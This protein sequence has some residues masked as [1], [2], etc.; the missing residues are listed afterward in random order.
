MK[1]SFALVIVVIASLLSG[2][3]P[4]SAQVKVSFA[5]QKNSSITI[6]GSSNIT[7]FK[8]I[9]KGEKLPLETFMITATPVQNK[10]LISENRLT[11]EVK[12]FT[13]GNKMALRDFFKLVKS[14]IYP[15]IRFQ[16]IYL[17]LD[18]VQ[19]EQTLQPTYV[20]AFVNITISGITKEYYI[21]IS[22]VSNGDFFTF[23]GRK[24]LSIRD[25]GLTP[26]VELIGLIKVSEWIDIDF[27]LLCKISLFQISA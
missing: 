13:S 10:M 26:P 17:E 5:F 12:N 23:C 16:L 6:Y 24:R 3:K 18:Q 1:R 2:S 11:V 7:S 15:T 9:L 22:A 4:L 27:N 20:N 21:P 14:D 8:L 19:L 25:F